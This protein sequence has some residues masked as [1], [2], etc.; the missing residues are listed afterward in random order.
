MRSAGNWLL[1]G[2]AVSLVVLAIAPAATA[3]A[4]APA[5]TIT[6][7]SN[8]G[9]ASS[10]TPSFS[11]EAE[12]GAGAVTLRIY[13]GKAPKGEVIEE[14]TAVTAGGAWSV[15]APGPLKN[16]NYTVQATQTNAVPE[17]GKSLPVTFSVDNPPPVVTLNSPESPSSNTTPSFT[18]T[19]SGTKPVSVVIHAGATTKGT[20]VSAATAAA[21]GG[22]FTSGAASPAL[23][24]GQYTA[25]ATQAS[26][27]AGNP[28]GHSEPATFTVVPPAVSTPAL[29]PPLAPPVASFTWFP[30]VP[31]TGESVS[32]VSTASDTTSAI[33]GLAWALSGA[34]PFQPGG[35]VLATSFSAPGA[36][37]VRLL[38]TNAYGLSS[39]ATDTINV[40]G[41]R[42]YLMQPYPVV[43]I[44]GSETRS[45]VKLRLLQVQQ[46]PAGARITVRCTGRRCPVRSASRVAASSKRPVPAVE[47]RVFERTLHVGVT[48]EILI[49][50]PGEIGKYTRFSIR[51]GRLPLR[52]DT[53]LDPTGVKPVACPAS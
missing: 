10:E 7:P 53:C 38:V 48:L 19:A 18:G 41:P 4:A 52:V 12:Q 42:V 27:L 2:A 32:L 51:R 31:Q 29:L 5:V 28:P 16:G 37:A 11:G 46:L 50:A 33:T 22:S 43:R 14:F 45:G 6:S 35:A 36:H 24:S 30:F 9:E 34:G 13:V 49:S 8:G 47:F 39:V 15:D 23:S 40:V 25:I 26:Q 1:R 17:T 44:V 21:N 3:N 20:V